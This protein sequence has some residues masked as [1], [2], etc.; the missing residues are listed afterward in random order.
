MQDRGQTT[1]W[2]R[3]RPGWSDFSRDAFR[4][5]TQSASRLKPLQQV[6]STRS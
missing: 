2:K 6:S 1:K 4:P 3:A 5:E